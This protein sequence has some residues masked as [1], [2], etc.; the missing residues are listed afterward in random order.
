MKEPEIIYVNQ[1]HVK[2][3]N[4]G[5]SIGHPLVYL[6]IKESQVICPYCSK[7]FRKKNNEIN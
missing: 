6:E 1:S 4:Q 5:G 3:D 2:C 7:I